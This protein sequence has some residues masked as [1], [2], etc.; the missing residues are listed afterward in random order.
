MVV[1]LPMIDIDRYNKSIELICDIIPIRNRKNVKFMLIEVLNRKKVSADNLVKAITF[2]RSKIETTWEELR[3]YEF[4][5]L[6]SIKW[7]I[8]EA[9]ELIGC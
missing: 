7:L 5:K 2:Y 8:L 3:G 9:I 4:D 6:E 1:M